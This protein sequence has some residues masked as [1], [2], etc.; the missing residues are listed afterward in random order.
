MVDGLAHLGAIADG[1]AAD[2]VTGGHGLGAQIAGHVQ[3]VAELHRLI[4]ADAGDRRL[5]T[6]IAVGEL[7]DDR[8]PEA[9]FII[10]HI[11]GDADHL[12]GQPGVVDVLAGA[13]GAFFLQRRAVVVELQGHA[14]HVIA[15]LRQQGCHHSGVHPARHGRHHPR[16][17]GQ[18]H[19]GARG[20]DRRVHVGARDVR[21]RAGG[22]QQGHGRHLGAKD[23]EFEAAAKGKG[24]ALADAALKP[25][26]KP[27]DYWR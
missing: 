7:V 22:L 6:Q 8:V 18:A 5:A 3:Q 24:R 25:S 1:G 16:A 14:H 12:G 2:V 26:E 19:R 20:L 27:R 9:A 11:M 4:A 23:G 21:H 15:G 13:A 17:H 10:Q